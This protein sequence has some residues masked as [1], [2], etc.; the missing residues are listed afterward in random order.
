MGFS[1]YFPSEIYVDSGSRIWFDNAHS[2]FF[3][4]LVS[5]GIVG[6]LAYFFLFFLAFF[7]LFRTK[8]I[9]K[10]SGN[11]FISLLA[12]YIFANLFVFD[13]INTYILIVLV[14]AFIHDQ[15]INKEAKEFNFS[16]FK[17]SILVILLVF[18]GFVGYRLN[19]EA[20]KQNR[21]LLG[22]QAYAQAEEITTANELY[23]KALE[24]NDNPHTR[25]EIRHYYAVFVR[26]NT[27]KLA[28][29]EKAS[30]FDKVIAEMKK[31]IAEDPNEIKYYYSLAQLYLKSYKLN[32]SRLDKVIDM[33]DK[34]ID[35][36]PD[37]AHTY[38][39]IGE[40]YVFKKEYSSALEMFQQAVKLNSDVVD[41]YINV[42]AVS[43]LTNNLELEKQ[44][45][46]NII[47][48][49]PNFFDKEEGLT[50]F[51][52]LYK[53]MNRQE[54][55]VHDMEKL[56][57]LYPEKIEYYST[58]AIF[59]AEKGENRKSEETIKLLLGR[60]AEL[61]LEIQNFIQKIHSGEFLK[62]K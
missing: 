39:Q 38:F 41:T 37:R 45:K 27:A 25:F 50:R 11:I 62:K 10:L 60:N 57:K 32:P 33:K 9:S 36:A 31:S 54:Q 8:R 2:V 22:A 59:Y 34:M 24:K 18:L 13:T 61:D 49:H 16:Y 51:I 12:G 53:K 19:I 6:V 35:L 29:Y 43:I 23:L 56:I 20:V 1:K 30:M 15:I 48:L 4:H 42:L 28:N 14:L 21:Y 26:S 5:T 44:T 52:S 55:F 40:A 46:E 47:K 3:E 7:Y 58:L 17:F